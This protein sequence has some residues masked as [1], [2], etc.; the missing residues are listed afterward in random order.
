[1]YPCCGKYVP[2]GDFKILR[3]GPPILGGNVISQHPAHLLCL[4]P[5]ASTL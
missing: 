3:P 5:P 1:M 4:P 2:E